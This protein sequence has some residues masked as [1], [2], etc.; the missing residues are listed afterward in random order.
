METFLILSLWSV[1]KTILIGI[2][3]VVGGII[4]LLALLVIFII[5]NS[6]KEHPY[7]YDE[8]DDY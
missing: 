1:I 4:I 5:L 3:Y 2:L 6:P 7:M 8:Q